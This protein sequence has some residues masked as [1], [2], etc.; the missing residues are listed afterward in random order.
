MLTKM[1]NANATIPQWLQIQ[2]ENVAK[3]TDSSYLSRLAAWEMLTKKGFPSSKDEKWKY[4]D[5]SFLQK[6]AFVLANFPYLKEIKSLIDVCRLPAASSKLIVLIDGYF[7]PAYSDVDQLTNV[8]VLPLASVPYQSQLDI[9]VNQHQ[10]KDH[11]PFS[12]LNAAMWQDGIFLHVLPQSNIEQPIH[13]LS[14]STQQQGA[15]THPRHV[16]LVEEHAS[17]TLLEEYIS[18]HDDAYMTNVSTTILMKNAAKLQHYKIQQENKQAIHIAHTVMKQSANSEVKRTC[19]SIGGKFVRDDVTVKLEEQAAK[20]QLNGLYYANDNQQYI[21]Q[22]IMVDHLASDTQSEMLY[23]G[24]LDKKSRAVFDGHLLVA[25]EVQ[26]ITAFQANHNLLLSNKAEVY[27]KPTL[28]IYADDIKCKHGATIG[29]VSQDALFYL[30]SR[31]MDQL[32]AL[33]IL[34][35]AFM[36]DILEGIPHVAIKRHVKEVMNVDQAR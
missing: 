24:I 34:L 32:A 23:K 16:I 7:M 18:L 19:F 33:N 14:I 3:S 6:N 4:A 1:D 9:E 30:R 26:K 27:S 31:G 22:H 25:K 11:H 29:Q 12:Q 13:L 8:K 17:L 36:E 10:A 20:C 15:I 35:Q 21:D 28:E 2:W 5:L